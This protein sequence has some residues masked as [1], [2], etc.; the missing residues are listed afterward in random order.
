MPSARAA[1]L[2]GRTTRLPWSAATVVAGLYVSW[3]GPSLI[4]PATRLQ[5]IF[6]W[7]VLGY[8]I[9]GILFL[10]TGLQAREL[11]IGIGNFP[12]SL[13]IASAA[14]VTL[15]VILARFAW[16]YPATYLPRKLVPAIARADPSPP[17]QWPFMLAFTGV[18]GIDSLAAALAIPLATNSHAK[19]KWIARPV[20][21]SCSDGNVA[22]A[23]KARAV[24]CPSSFERP[25]TPVVSK[26]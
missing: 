4:S 17:W 18:R 12:K 26:R 3:N 22:H 7:D 10:L 24:G 25:R 2:A 5:G 6:F 20:P 8:L 11:I 1:D 15:V 14:V 13:L 16:I 19:T 21:R 23:G 9:E